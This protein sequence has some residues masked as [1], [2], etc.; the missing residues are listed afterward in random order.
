MARRLQL[1][2]ILLILGGVALTASEAAEIPDTP[3]GEAL[4][5]WLDAFNSGDRARIESFI[6]TRAPPQTLE[7][8]LRLRAL[9]GGLDLLAIESSQPPL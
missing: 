6:K 8:T 1:L 7:T 3:A 9:S 4:A 2:T 5:L